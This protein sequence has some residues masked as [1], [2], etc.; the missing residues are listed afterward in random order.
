[1][2]VPSDAG[3]AI[4]DVQ[5]MTLSNRN[6]ISTLGGIPVGSGPLSTDISDAAKTAIA[7]T[8]SQINLDSLKGQL[9]KLDLGPFKLAGDAKVRMANDGTAFLDAQAELKGA[10]KAGSGPIR[11]SVTVRAD[12]NGTLSLQ[13][14]HLDVPKALLGA[15]TVSGLKLDYD[16][17]GLSITGALLFPPINDGIAINKFRVDGNGNFQE[18]DVSYLAGRGQGIEI[19]PGMFL[20]KLGG[21][22]S[23]D[24]DEFRARAGISI[25]PSAGGGCPTAGVDADMNVHFGPGPFFVDANST[26]ELVCIPIGNAHFHADA[27]GAASVSANVHLDLNP[28]Y[29]TAG[30]DGELR[31]PDW[32]VDLHGEGGIRHVLTGTVKGIISNLGLAGCGRVELF[33]ATPFTDSVTAAGGAGIHFSTASRRSPT[34]SCWRTSTCSRAAACAAGARS[35]AT[36]RARRRPKAASRSRSARRS[37]APRRSR[38]T[39][40][41]GR[42]W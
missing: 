11:T 16:G 21:G 4:A 13:G 28:F 20:V 31:L 10:F 3:K 22:L 23:L 6:V 7:P 1:M 5:K 33:P 24:P 42:R 26:V 37:S 27:T 40:S 8:L 35:A 32:Q 9:S 2:I 17:N 41:A 12:R 25:G 30:I 15:V 14:V 18:L 39:A 29:V 34:P 19:G 36:W 38:S